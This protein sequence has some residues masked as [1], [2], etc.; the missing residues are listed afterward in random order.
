RGKANDFS[1][2]PIPRASLTQAAI[3]LSADALLQPLSPNITCENEWQPISCRVEQAAIPSTR[4]RPKKRGSVFSFPRGSRLDRSRSHHSCS[5][6]IM[7]GCLT[8][9]TVL[10]L[11]RKRWPTTH[12]VAE[13]PNSSNKASRRSITTSRSILQASA[14]LLGPNRSSVPQISSKSRLIV[15]IPEGAAFDSEPPHSILLAPFCAHKK[16]IRELPEDGHIREFGVG[17][18]P[19]P[20]Q[21]RECPGRRTL[22]PVYGP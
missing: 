20:E 11:S 16:H 1:C 5:G 19:G 13:I 21:T 22:D 15:R 12:Q 17:S 8:P 4:L 9:S 6:R 7:S 18:F 14:N 3:S 2:T 10:Q